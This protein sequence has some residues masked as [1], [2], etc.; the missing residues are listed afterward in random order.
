MN[1]KKIIEKGTSAHRQ[2]RRYDEIL[3]TG[4]NNDQALI[5]V[6]DQLAAETR[7]FSKI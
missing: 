5:A 2:V 7:D 1:L 3:G 6:V 4:K